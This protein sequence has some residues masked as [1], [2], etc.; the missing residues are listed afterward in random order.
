M[1]RTESLLTRKTPLVLAMF[2]KKYDV[3][4]VATDSSV[5]SN[6]PTSIAQLELKYE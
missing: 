6:T 1:L 3:L 5:I 2:P 4:M